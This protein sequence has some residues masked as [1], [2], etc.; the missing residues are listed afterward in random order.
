MDYITF[1]DWLQLD[2]PL[3]NLKNLPF[4]S[5][6]IRFIGLNSCYN[7]AIQT[8]EVSTMQMISTAKPRTARHYPNAASRHYFLDKITDAILSAAICTGVITILFFLITML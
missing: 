7:E 5:H 6:Y 4:K 3:R 2:K 8:K 1:S